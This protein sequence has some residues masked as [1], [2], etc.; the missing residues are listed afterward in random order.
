MKTDD[1]RAEPE[2]EED[3]APSKGRRHY[4]N[5]PASRDE[6]T[7]MISDLAKELL[8]LTE[9]GAGI[10]DPKVMQYHAMRRDLV[11]MLAEE[12]GEVKFVKS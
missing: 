1:Y 3:Q 4:R 9:S 7:A 10:E 12:K 11:Q 6:I 8:V 5:H 2:G